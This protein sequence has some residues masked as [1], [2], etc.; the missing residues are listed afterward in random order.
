[1]KSH[2]SLT[3]QCDLLMS[4]GLEVDNVDGFIDFLSKHNYYH[5]AGYLH[6]FLSQAEGVVSEQFK[7]G[8]NSK[9]IQDL[10]E[11]DRQLRSLLFDAL[12]V[13]ETRFRGSL[14]YHVGRRNPFLHI[15]GTG[16]IKEFL[17]GGEESP[18]N[19]WL[20]GYE[21]AVQKHKGNELVS[22]QEEFNDERLPIWAAVEI[23]D[24]GK[25]SRLYRGLDEELASKIGLD[26]AGK[27][28]FLK[29]AVASLNNLRNH[30]AHH[31]RIWNFHF[32][33]NPTLRA[34]K[35]P[36]EL[37]HL[38]QQISYAKNK[39]FTRLSLL[40]WFDKNKSFDIDFSNRLFAL[41]RELPGSPS[42]SLQAM[43]YSEVFGE[44]G[45]WAGLELDRASSSS[46]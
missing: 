45:V 8:T 39:L 46:V 32:A 13:F 6:P 36:T 44:S 11:F 1:M 41:L 28:V 42:L 33:I 5:L 9:T 31:G 24:F 23:L 19:E 27:A 30:V 12:A 43:G 29:G 22:W 17:D 2:L 4:R 15:E 35:L 21:A 38:S 37:L 20:R 7:P 18:Y 10:V 34:T 14:A 25:V 26:F 16:F 40:L 3:E